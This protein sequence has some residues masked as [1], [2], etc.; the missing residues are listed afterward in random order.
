MKKNL[1]MLSIITLVGLMSGCNFTNTSST[2]N[3]NTNLESIGSTSSINLTTSSSSTSEVP[4]FVEATGVTL[5]R[6]TVELLITKDE[7][8]PTVTL[9][10][11]VTPDNATDKSVAWSSSDESIATVENGVVKGLKT[12][13]ATITVTKGDFKDI[14]EV[15]VKTGLPEIEDKKISEIT[16]LEQDKLYKV[17][18]LIQ[19]I[20]NTT[21]GNFDLLDP[22]TEAS[23]YING[24]GSKDTMLDDFYWSDSKLNYSNSNS[25]TS[26]GLANGDYITLVGTYSEHNGVPQ[27]SGYLENKGEYTTTASISVNNEAMGYATLSKKKD[28]L[29]GEKIIVTPTPLAG[30][31]VS[32]ITLNGEE[33]VETNGE[34]SFLA[35]G[36]NEVMVNFALD[37]VGKK[38]TL[39]Y[40][41]ETL[42]GTA[43]SHDGGAHFLVQNIAGCSGDYHLLWFG[44]TVGAS[45]T[46]PVS[47]PVTGTYDLSTRF[48]KAIDFAIFDV[49]LND[50]KILE[51][52]DG[53]SSSLTVGED[54]NLGSYALE[55]G[56][57]TLKIVV[58]GKN[59]ASTGY[60]VCMD[61][62]E[63]N[64]LPSTNKEGV[65]RY[66]MENLVPKSINNG[67][68]NH[69]HQ[70]V[71]FA[72]YSGGAQ[73]LWFGEAVGSTLVTSFNVRE[74]GSYELSTA[75][76]KARD[77]AIINMYIDGEKVLENYDLYGDGPSGKVELGN[78]NL[79]AGVHTITT[80]IVGKNEASTGYLAGIDYLEMKYKTEENYTR[81]EAEDYFNLA[82][83][84]EG[85][86]MNQYKDSLYSNRGAVCLVGTQNS[87][88]EFDISVSKTAEYDVRTAMVA[89]F[90]LAKV[91]VYIDGIAIG[92]AI[93][94]Y[95]PTE[96]ISDIALLGK[97]SL[98]KGVHTIKFVACD[99]NEASA[100]YV[101]AIDY[102]DL[103]EVL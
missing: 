76:M 78:L 57:Y 103:V 55:A 75:F 42:Y 93:D 33:L 43:E 25:F 46:V 39:R 90:D 61:Y 27:L 32:N 7:M 94:C 40:E 68:S 81:Y 74:T 41:M 80:E 88:I 102:V 29:Y 48:T 71:D 97:V 79:T 65:I 72:K 34:Y 11:K 18:G 30:Y 51:N 58:K 89:A 10:V 36:K 14:C 84:S 45:M 16:D 44:E 100:G 77:F 19:N 54:V 66:E 20:T 49:Y 52:Y 63:M 92:N 59:E 62:L 87:F 98:T 99:K 8:N 6:K 83:V 70:N 24:L 64:Y 85:N 53:Y 56:T 21:Y 47:A 37:S 69:Y 1:K 86:F 28:I 73:L 22:E 96:R 35:T 38:R 31:I 26:L 50:T 9:V 17:T 4:S 13:S 3:S 95:A 101:M 12:G 5:D 15:T 23:V 60:I 67:G 91:Q 2:K 82:K